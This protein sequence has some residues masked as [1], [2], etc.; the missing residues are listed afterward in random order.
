[1]FRGM[2]EH[3]SSCY[4][5]DGELPQGSSLFK[6][7]DT[8]TT[9]TFGV[10]LLICSSVHHPF[11]CLFLILRRDNSKKSHPLRGWLPFRG[12]FICDRPANYKATGGVH[13]LSV[14]VM[15][16][17]FFLVKNKIN[18]F[19]EIVFINPGLPVAGAAF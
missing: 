4:D 1:M 14:A 8:L 19:L 11:T 6:D 2:K 3:W 5:D 13:V 18:E 15:N 17:S 9:S 10:Q 12:R 7:V 16:T